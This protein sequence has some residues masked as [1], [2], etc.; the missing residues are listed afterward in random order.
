M[1]FLYL[2]DP[3]FVACVVIYFVNRFFLKSVFTG[4]FC[5][6]S[7]ND[8]ICIPFWVPIMLF[9]QRGMRLRDGDY[10]PLAHEVLIP[11]VLWSVIFEI[12][13]PRFELFKDLCV[14]D[15]MDIFY[16]SL[17]TLIAAIFWR[18]WYRD[19]PAAEPR[20]SA[21]VTG[22]R[23]CCTPISAEKHE[24]ATQATPDEPILGGTHTALSG[25]ASD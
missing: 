15:Y 22:Q 13:L 5:H 8:L 3:L 16:Y 1:R 12:V 19:E 17:G 23:Q 11:L 7:L 24:K 21:R 2:R 9:A 14:A 25:R 10:P 6:E 18:L 20:S 4:G